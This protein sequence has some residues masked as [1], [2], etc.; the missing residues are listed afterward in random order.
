LLQLSTTD[1]Y[2]DF[3]LLDTSD[4]VAVHEFL[5]GSKAATA[6]NDASRVTSGRKS[7]LSPGHTG[8]SARRL[9]AAKSQRA[10]SNCSPKLNSASDGLDDC[11]YGFDMD[12]GCDASRESDNSDDDSDDPWKPLNPHELGNL[13]VK[14]FRKGPP[15]SP[16]S[17]INILPYLNC[18]TYLLLS[19]CCTC[20]ENFKKE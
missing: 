20:S 5:E 14:P 11:N 9:S 2:Q 8:G 15:N 19:F 13:R 3:I 4:A 7:F 16:K 1:L 18:V 10:N 6:R 12:H 17:F